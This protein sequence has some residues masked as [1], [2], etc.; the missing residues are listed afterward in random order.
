MNQSALRLF[1]RSIITEAKEAK[2]TK[3]AETK[4]PKSSG[5][6][7]DLKKELAALEQYRDEIQVAKF[8]E[9]TAETEV[10]FADLAKFKKE[11]DAIKEKGVKLESDLEAKIE[12]IKA[13]IDVQKNKIKEMIG[14]VPKGNQKKIEDV[15]DP[16][17][18]EDKPENQEELDADQKA[19][20]DHEDNKLSQYDEAKKSSAGMTK[21]AKSAVAKK[22]HAGGDIGKKGKGFK[23]VEKAAEKEYGSKEAGQKVAAAAMWKGQAKK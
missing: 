11:L 13:K 20:M 2:E 10:E 6:L 16:E 7:M 22:A 14:M 1:V 19:D 8:A 12:E 23:K 21:K 5:K 15:K 3:K 4:L 18:D 9:K 17:E